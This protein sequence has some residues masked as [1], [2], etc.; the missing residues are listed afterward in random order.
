MTNQKKFKQYLTN[1]GFLVS[2][3][4]AILSLVPHFYKTNTSGSALISGIGISMF[5]GVNTRE[6]D[7]GCVCFFY[8]GTL[9]TKYCR[10]IN[11]AE[12]QKETS[13]YSTADDAIKAFEAWRIK[14]AKI[15][16]EQWTLIQ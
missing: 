3:N 4:Y 6:G 5:T 13:V 8:E 7:L 10:H 11:R 15:L 12:M 1:K 14:A 9:R 2:P 16:A